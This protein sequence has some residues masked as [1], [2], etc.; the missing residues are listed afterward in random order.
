MGHTC[1]SVYAIYKQ[2]HIKWNCTYSTIISMKWQKR[3]IDKELW[4]E[5]W[6]TCH[7]QWSGDIKED[8]YT[9]GVGWGY[10]GSGWGKGRN[11]LK[12]SVH[13]SII[14]KP[15]TLYNNLKVKY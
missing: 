1:D 15:A 2:L 13:E 14:H 6:S 9:G 4:G 10:T 3:N 11:Q 8:S 5:E 7:C 12:F